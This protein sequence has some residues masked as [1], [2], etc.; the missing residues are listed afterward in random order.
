[1][2]NIALY[3]IFNAADT[4]NL[5]DLKGMLSLPDTDID[6]DG[7]IE[8]ET[9]LMKAARRGSA[10]VAQAL[11]NRDPGLLNA[12]IT[13]HSDFQTPK[14][15][16]QMAESE[17][18]ISLKTDIETN[19]PVVWARAIVECDEAKQRMEDAFRP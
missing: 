7:K 10:R 11:M 1:M 9:A 19:D 16:A 12:N 6:I 18:F 15:A 5:A 17:G 2:P 13:L 4:D 3:T 14:T 8:G